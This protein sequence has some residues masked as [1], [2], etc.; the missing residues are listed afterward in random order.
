M[1]PPEPPDRPAPPP[2][3]SPAGG[4]LADAGPG[5]PGKAWWERV[6]EILAAVSGRWAV[7]ILRHLASGESR[8]ADLL[9]AINATSE[10]RLSRKVLFEALGRLSESGLIRRQQISRRPPETHYWLT[11]SGHEI[12]NQIS[13]LG[14]PDTGWPAMGE[15]PAESAHDLD[16]HVAHPARIWNV[17]LAGKDNFAADREAASLAAGAMPGL[18]V[19]ARL[20]RRYQADAIRLLLARGVRQFLDIGTGLPAAGSVHEIAQ[21]DAPESRVVYVDNDPLVLVHARALLT[22]SPE[23]ACAYVHAD[24]REPGTI[25]GEAARTL[26]LSQPVG[27]LL[28][29]VLHFIPDNEDPWAITRRLMDGIPGDAYLVMGHGASDIRPGE[30]AEMARKYN[31]RSATPITMRTKDEVT[32]FFDGLELLPPGVVPVTRWW[33]TPPEPVPGTDLSGYAGIGWRPARGGASARR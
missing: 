24:L 13:T 23:G 20:T 12:L 16:T 29:G 25:L 28:I 9:N 14:T 32:G 11:D 33:R 8:P 15:N 27:V 26:D 22:S 19:I 30:S 10:A 5:G 31:Q 2:G 6:D 1:G 4:G 18:P 7:P 3:D 21:R 17:Y